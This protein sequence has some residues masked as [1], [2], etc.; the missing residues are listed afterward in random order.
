MELQVLQRV[1]AHIE[2]H[3]WEDKPCLLDNAAL[4]KV[5][6]LSVFHFLREFRAAAGLSAADYIRK[7]RISEIVKRMGEERP[8]SDI[9][10]EYGFNS[11]EHFTRAFK[12]EHG[13][14]PS[15][16]K[17]AGCSLRLYEPLR[18]SPACVPPK[19]SLGYLEE[20]SLTVYPFGDLHPPKCWNLYNTQHR[21][22]KLSGGRVAEDHGVMY[23]HK[24]TGRLDYFIGIP[25]KEAAGDR[26]GTVELRF[27][28]GLYAIFETPPATQHEFSA[29]IRDTWDYIREE[30]FPKSGYL[31]KDGY[32]LE[33]YTE[34]SRTYTET[35]YIPIE[36]KKEHEI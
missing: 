9:A 15:A 11:K 32:E 7:R 29:V 12:K 28:G 30:W 18:L 3:L 34:A 23:F 4:A 25:T 6:G 27:P 17:K 5:A 20:I 10:F 33:T 19:V 21:S 22:A 16:Y 26:E 8:M 36:R 31:R 2:E 13:V 35:I 24:D 1:I 14:L